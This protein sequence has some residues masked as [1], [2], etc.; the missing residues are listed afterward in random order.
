MPREQPVIIGVGNTSCLQDTSRLQETSRSCIL[1]ATQYIYIYI[2][3][4][5]YIYIYIYKD[6][7][8]RAREDWQSQ[9][10]ERTE[11]EKPQSMYE[12]KYKAAWH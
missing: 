7:K 2:Y 8:K 9:N 3:I 11:Q 4:H 10:M 5:I 1:L 12:R 6:S